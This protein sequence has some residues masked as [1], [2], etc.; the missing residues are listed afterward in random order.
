MSAPTT[1]L[2][3]VVLD[4]REVRALRDGRLSMLVRPVRRPRGICDVCWARALAQNVGALTTPDGAPNAAGAIFGVEPYLIVPACDHADVSGARVRCPLGAPGERRF[5]RETWKVSSSGRNY[6]CGET[7]VHVE[8]REQSR[9]RDADRGRQ[10]RERWMIDDAGSDALLREAYGTG[11]TGRWRPS[12]HMP[13]WASRYTIEIV[14]VEARRVQSATN[15]EARAMGLPEWDGDEPGDY[16]GALRDEWARKHGAE[17][18][19]RNDWL[20][21]VGVRRVETQSER[22]A[23]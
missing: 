13:R 11:R 3:G 6:V 2:R 14:S 21:L 4:A 17:S 20:W 16:R 18:W 19:D 1:K 9:N 5:V 22:G 15:N 7:N 12:I 10:Y 23:A 8:Y